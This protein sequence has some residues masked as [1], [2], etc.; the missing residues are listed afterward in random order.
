[1]FVTITDI[2]KVH[3]GFSNQ[4]IKNFNQQE[5]TNRFKEQ[6]VPLEVKDF[7]LARLGSE[8]SF[9]YHIGHIMVVG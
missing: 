8:M 6:K 1:M 4:H 2:E 3:K 9:S 7:K 5:L